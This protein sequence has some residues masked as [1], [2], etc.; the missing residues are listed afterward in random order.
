MT[1][2]KLCGL[3]RP[4][5]VE[6]AN[7]LRPEFAG[8]VFAP[9]SRR[10]VSSDA[11]AALRSRLG[12]GIVPVGVF[13]DADAA[14][15][16]S[17]VREGVID[18][19][20]LHGTEDDAVIDDLRALTNAVIVQ[21]FQISSPEDVL[22]AKRSH[23]DYVLLDAGAGCGQTFDWN[24]VHSLDRPWF[25]AGGL[26]PDNVQ[27][28]IRQAMPWAVDVSSGIETAGRKDPL[29]MAAFCRNARKENEFE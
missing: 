10:Y 29:K 9:T 7:A 25:L 1:R 17:L 12:P 15:I 24:M 21:A 2:I 13:V 3:T 8:F 18:W 27:Q 20:Q 22:R 26:R 16:A 11:A 19:V 6:A 4:E 5:D 14:E 23:A 28:A